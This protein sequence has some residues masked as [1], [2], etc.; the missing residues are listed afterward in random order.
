MWQEK[1]HNNRDDHN[2]ERVVKQSRFQN[3]GELDK[4]WKLESGN[5]LQVSPS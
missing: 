4:E 3:S 1:V 5:G 2:L